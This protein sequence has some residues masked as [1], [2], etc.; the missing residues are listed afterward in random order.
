MD[1]DMISDF[2]FILGDMNYRMKGT[3]DQLVPQIDK[4]IEMRKD[5]D[6]LHISMTEL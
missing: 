3:Y 5:L 4:L 1:P 2:N 6:Q